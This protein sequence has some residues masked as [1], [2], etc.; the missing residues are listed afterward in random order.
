MFSRGFKEVNDRV[1]KGSKFT[2]S[3][4]HCEYYYQDTGDSEEVCQNPDVLQYDMVVTTTTIYCNRWKPVQRKSPT[5]FKKGVDIC[6]RKKS[7]LQKA[8][9]IRSK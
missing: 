7:I 9:K 3:C 4:Y 8:R 1:S 6:G 2:M 5:K